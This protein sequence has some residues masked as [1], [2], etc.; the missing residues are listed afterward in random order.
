MGDRIGDADGVG[1]WGR[2]RGCRRLMRWLVGL[3]L[4]GR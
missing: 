3:F 2:V 4:L 1:M